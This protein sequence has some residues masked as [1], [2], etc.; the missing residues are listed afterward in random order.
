MNDGYIRP[1]YEGARTEDYTWP[2]FWLSC[3]G[4]ALDTLFH[5]RWFMIVI[6]CGCPWPIS[7]C[8]LSYLFL[9]Q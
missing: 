6:M 5:I 1:S 4:I 9:L 7:Y 2:L 3:V 8:G